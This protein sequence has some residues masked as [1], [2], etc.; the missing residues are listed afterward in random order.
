MLT[1]TDGLAAGIEQELWV[2]LL[3]TA[4]T[5]LPNLDNYLRRPRRRCRS[6]PRT[7]ASHRATTRPGRCS[8]TTR[9]GAA[10]RPT[11]PE[12]LLDW[13]KAHPGKFQYARPANSGPG[14]TFLMG[15]PY[16]L[17]DTDPKDPV[18]GWDKT[19]AYLKELEQVRR[20]LPVRHGRDDEEP[21]QRH[22]G[23]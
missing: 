1:G 9:A 20:L 14:R 5:A 21:G 18:N 10:P 3:P 8:S 2:P 13:A 12:E 23:R 6:S 4:T 11:T 19:W 15:L 17:G 16:L 22:V 7:T